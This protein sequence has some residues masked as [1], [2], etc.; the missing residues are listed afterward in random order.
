V[1]FHLALTAGP[2]SSA[3]GIDVDARLHR[4]LQKIFL[5]LDGDLSLAG[6]KGNGLFRHGDGL[7]SI[8]AIQDLIVAVRPSTHSGRTV[9]QFILIV[10]RFVRGEL[11]VRRAHHIR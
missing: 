9:T 7:F 3:R 2:A 6:L 1:N 10:S 8:K 11:V 5:S 4:R